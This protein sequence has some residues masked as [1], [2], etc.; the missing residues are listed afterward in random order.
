M[1][2]T[3]DTR[4]YNGKKTEVI[5]MENSN[6]KCKDLDDFPMEVFDAVGANLASTKIIC[7]G[8]MASTFDKCFVYKEGGWQYFATMIEGRQNAAGIVNNNTF[9]IFGGCNRTSGSYIGL[10]SSEIVNEDGSSYEGPQLPKAM[11][12][13]AIASVNSTVSII[14][15][16]R[17]STCTTTYLCI[18]RYSDQTWYFNHATQEFQ[19]GPNLLE[20]RRYHSSGTITDQETKEKLVVVAG[21]KSKSGVSVWSY[22]TDSTE[23]LLNGNWVIGK[24][25]K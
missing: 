21:G 8:G 24:N 17:T 23:I 2:S 22:Y 3:G 15:G 13:H 14:S 12:L 6:V 11:Y 25:H 16:G 7:G 10:Q 1:I 19:P 20:A 9:H 5:D 18:D 4:N